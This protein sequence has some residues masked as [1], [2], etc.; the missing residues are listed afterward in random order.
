MKKIIFSN[1]INVFLIAGQSY[2]DELTGIVLDAQNNKPISDVNIFIPDQQIG[3]TTDQ[4]GSFVIKGQLVFPIY[5]QISHIG[6][7]SINKVID[8]KP[9]ESLTVYLAQ[10][11][12][13]MDELVVT[14][15]RSRR[16]RSEAPIA[17]EVISKRKFWVKKCC[18]FYLKEP[19]VCICSRGSI[20][21]VLGMDRYSNTC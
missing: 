19:L 7:Q 2:D 9:E 3:A 16:F 6:Y 11:A 21:N 17:T 5:L 18:D 8:A 15:T 20:L 14:A 12:I 1:I 4:N 10:M 13:E